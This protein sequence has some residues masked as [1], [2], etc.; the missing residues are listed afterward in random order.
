MTEPFKA[1]FLSYASQDAE[2]ARRICEALRASGI[3][4]WFDQSELRGGD[5][6][7]QQIRQQIHDCTLFI[8]IISAHTDA[9]SEG[10]FRLEWKLAVDRSHLMADDTAFLVPVVIDDTQDTAARVPEKFRTV[11]WTRLPAGQTPAAFPQ[12]VSALLAGTAKP[13][14]APAGPLRPATQKSKPGRRIAIAVLA[15]GAIALFSWREMT[16]APSGVVQKVAAPAASVIPEHSIAVL[17][18]VDV[19][20]R[21]DQEYFSDGLSEALLNLLSK[22]PGLQ[23]AART[24][25]FS[26]KGH[27][28]DVPTIGRKLRVAHVLE[29]SIS[30]VGNHLRVTAQLERADTGYQIWSETYDR[31]L[32]DVF[33]IQDE[34]AAAVVKAL[35]ISLLGSAAPQSLGTQNSDA[36]LVFLQGRAKMATQRL[37]D[38]NEAITEFARALKLDPNYAPAYVELA[39]AKLQLAEFGATSDRTAAFGSAIDEGKLLIERALALDPNDAQAYVERGYL[40]AFSDLAGAEKDYRRGIELNPNSA[41]GYEGLAGVLFDDPKRRD[42]A[43][44]M[45]TR[46]QRLDPLEPK[47]DVLKARCLLLGRGNLR[48]ADALLVDVVA[49]YPNYEPGFTQLAFVR[50]TEGNYADAIMYS[51]RALKLDPLSDWTRRLLILDYSAVADLAGARQVADEAPDRLPI[52]RLPLLIAEGNWHQAAEVTYA[53]L[54]DGTMTP[55]SEPYSVFALR[56]DAHRTH[57]FGRARA[58][59]E[60]MCGVTWSAAGIPMLPPQLGFGYASVALADMLIASGERER[61]ERLLR[62]S[63]ADMDFVAH[64]LKRGEL[65]YVIDRAT[66]LALLG[67]RKAALAALPKAVDAGYLSTWALTE[68][69]PAFDVLRADAEFLTQMRAIKAKVAREQQALAQMRSDGR[70]PDRS[71]LAAPKAQ[72]TGAGSS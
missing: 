5:A 32:G 16:R 24:S 64:D 35:K 18:F 27:T 71:G 7:D 38:T 2:A 1:V 15:V 61:G 67:D 19:S 69:D 58:V 53:A 33:R 47:Y 45:I 54:A 50:R 4:V 31:E 57:D 43:L 48:E 63:L 41:R 6:W 42:E 9:R 14:P 25:A 65:W 56:M 11:Q 68:L 28:V 39:T 8:P 55:P 52:Q 21:K 23:V 13:S 66:A 36:Y 40:R 44:A 34:I 51:E 20:A 59:F 12:R 17:P 29:G 3:E 22:V 62:A 30:K 70:V 72:A 46:A 60:R 10:Y 26:F 37:V 49:R